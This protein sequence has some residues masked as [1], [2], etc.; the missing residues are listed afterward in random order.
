MLAR[1]VRSQVGRAQVLR[2]AMSS[3]VPAAVLEHDDFTC[4]VEQTGPGQYKAIPVSD[5]ELLGK[6]LEQQ[7]HAIA[8]E[9]DEEVSFSKAIGLTS[10]WTWAPLVGASMATAISSEMYVLNE[11]TFVM[12]CLSGAGFLAW[13]NFGGEVGKAYA[14][15]SEDILKAQNE[16]EE[17]HIAACQTFVSRAGGSATLEADIAAAFEERAALVSAEVVAK[18]HKERLATRAEFVRK[19]DQ[20]VNIK[21]DE[22]NQMFKDLLAEAEVFVAKAAQEESFKKD[23][24]AYAI[25]ALSD[26]KKAPSDPAGGLY[27][28]F[29]ESKGMKM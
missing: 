20:M 25:A 14:D 18:A 21:A 15:F 3:N 24:L 19:L 23:A 12:L 28:K 13:L 7:A 10:G 1:V 16:A 9:P 2:R 26:P 17:K 6:Y 11:E 4:V 27:T 8:A 5:K 29:F 22:E